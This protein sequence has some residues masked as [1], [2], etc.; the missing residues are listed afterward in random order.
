MSG[1]LK[2]R[3]PTCGHPVL[4]RDPLAILQPTQRAV[5]DVIY[6]A[7]Q[8]GITADAIRERVWRDADTAPGSNIVA[9]HVTAINK[10]IV[11]LDMRVVGESRPKHYRVVSTHDQ[12]DRYGAKMRAE[13]AARRTIHNGHAK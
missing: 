1:P 6:A 2:T 9:I 8:L 13:S 11:L 12:R 10:R 3:C 4:P 5:F 7:G